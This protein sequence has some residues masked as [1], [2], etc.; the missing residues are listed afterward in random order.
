MMGRK[1][2]QGSEPEV[3]PTIYEDRAGDITIITPYR[4]DFVSGLKECIPAKHREFFYEEKAWWVSHV[5]APQ[6]KDI[7][8]LFW[9]DILIIEL[10][11]GLEPPF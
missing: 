11:T 5:Y 1:Q 10:D 3:Q 8:R 4:P 7:A 6:A 2:K 9:D